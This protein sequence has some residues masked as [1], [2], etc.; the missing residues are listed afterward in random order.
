MIPIE[1]EILVVSIDLFSL[2]NCTFLYNEVYCTLFML[3][4]CDVIYAL[5][6]K[7]HEGTLST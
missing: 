5:D 2:S 3:S 4:I 6:M 1:I 7:E